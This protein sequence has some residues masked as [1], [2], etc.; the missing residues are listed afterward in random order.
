M[1]AR[2]FISFLL[3][4]CSVHICS[5]DDMLYFYFYIFLYTCSKPHQFEILF[6]WF[7]SVLQ[8]DWMLYLYIHIWNKPCRI[9]QR[10]KKSFFLF[11]MRKKNLHNLYHFYINFHGGFQFIFLWKSESVHT[12]LFIL[13]KIRRGFFYYI[14][15]G[16]DAHKS[17]VF[18]TAKVFL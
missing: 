8:L 3:F 4:F 13:R 15:V 16:N 5:P 10:K 6:G 17:I 7:K 14:F 1:K 9:E 12:H 18:I 11:L 2:D